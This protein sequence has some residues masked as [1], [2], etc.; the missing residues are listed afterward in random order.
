M[1]VQIILDCIMIIVLIIG[2]VTGKQ[3]EISA[4]V[5]L[6]W[7]FIALFAHLQLKENDSH[8]D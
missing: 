1:I 6:I 4:W 3:T 7:V 8:R 5:G 2:I